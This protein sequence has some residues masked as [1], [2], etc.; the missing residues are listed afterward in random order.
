M[1]TLTT[2][3]RPLPGWHLLALA[4]AGLLLV[5]FCPGRAAAE[6]KPSSDVLVPYF[7]VDLDAPMLGLTTLFAVVNDDDK[8][9]STVVRVHSN[10]GIPIL[11][12]PMSI[13]PDEVRSFNLRDWVVYGRLPDRQLTP[14]EIAHVQAA[15]S[16]KPSPK[17]GLY[18]GS[19]T[20]PGLAVGYVVIRTTGPDRPD[21]LWGDYYMIDAQR[22]YFGAE[23]LVNIDP[24]VEDPPTCLRHGVRFLNGGNL[25]HGTQLLFWTE[26]EWPP[27]PAPKPIA[28]WTVDTNLCVYDEPGHH[29]ED[30]EMDILPVQVVKVDEL[31]LQPRFGWLDITTGERSF[32][33]EHLHTMQAPSA[34]LH[35]YCLPE[36]TGP[37][38]AA[39]DIQKYINGADA[40]F[41]PGPSIPVGSNLSWEFRVRNVGDLPLTDVVVSDGGVTVTCP[42]TELAPNESMTC[43][44]GG[45][46]KACQQQ[47][48][49]KVDALASDGTPVTDDDPA[50][51][52][53]QPHASLGLEKQVNGEDADG[54]DTDEGPWPH[55]PVGQ[56]IAWTFVVTNTGDVEL[57][58]VGVVDDQLPTVSCPKQVL[59]PG[60][61]MTCTASSPA[62][63]GTHRNVA[64]A[65]GTPPCGD[66]VTQ[67]DPANYVGWVPAPAIDLEKLVNGQDAD[68]PPGP[69]LELGAPVTWTF[70]VT[71][72]GDVPLSNVV[73]M[74]GQAAVSCPKTAL[75]TGESMT[76]TAQG[77]AQA[78]QQT[79]VASVT[80]QGDSTTVTD[81]DPA[82]YYGQFQASVSLEKRVNGEDADTEPGPELRTGT[83]ASWTYIAANTG[84]VRLT[85]VAVA[86]D[87]GVTVTCPK[88]VLEPGES[89]TCTGSA[90]VVKGQYRNVG[91]VTGKP[92]CGETV[93]ASDPANYIGRAPSI[94][95]EKLTNGEDADTP[96]GPQVEVGSTVLW[97]YVVTNT[98]DTVLT[99]IRVTD[100]RGVTVT[101]PK[102]E[103]QPAESMTCTASSMAVAGQY[104]NVGTAI[105]T[106]TVGP[107]VTATDPSHYFGY[108]SMIAIEKR[109]NGVDADTPPGPEILVGNPVTWKYWVT[110]TGDVPLTAVTVT[111]SDGVAVTCPQTT[112]AVSESMTC[113][114]SGTAVAGQHSNIGTATGNPPS[115]PSVSADDP[116]YYKGVTPGI[117]LEKLINGQDADSPPGPSIPVGSSLTWTYI[118]TNTG[119]VSLSGVGVTDSAGFTIVC[120]KTTLAPGES[121]TCTYGCA[122]GAV[123]C[124]PPEG[125]TALPGQQHNL[126]TATGT[127][128]D[129]T[130]VSDQD[131]AYY[132]GTQVADEG[133]TPGYWKN[134]TGSW[135]P[136]GYTTGQDVDTVFASVNTYYPTLGNASLWQALYFDGGS[137]NQ[138]A[139]EILL[140]A[141]VAALL[142]ASHPGVS[143]PRTEA[144]VIAD[145]N[146]ALLQSR[147]TML[148]LAAQLD[149]DNN[150]GCPLN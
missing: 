50:F 86:D 18:Y 91:T 49:G 134:H 57:T 42:Q 15:L 68:L 46:A 79:N 139:A 121:M 45:I 137:G 97:T 114:A 7:E 28:P 40:D 62:Q 52:F 4:L 11:T 125:C 5:L 38:G 26:R 115:G 22:S 101:C 131:H 78:C 132:F 102:T 36:E 94:S 130:P 27:S 39:I 73:V 31:D 69:T 55:I 30:H 118:V 6:I 21:V 150:L 100:D 93:T 25:T 34:T 32:I 16:G 148:A 88:T 105:G 113:S 135:P 123:K 81:T 44:L 14:A 19:E 59:Q 48:L 110:N 128:D 37:A 1:R 71:N 63:A 144:G 67:T 119:E 122:P 61:S 24:Q 126:G 104:A 58:D 136:T 47:N 74:D 2:G 33:T 51:Y 138:G 54:P 98:G 35:A 149:A 75:A 99:D 108:R 140:R 64:T 80:A 95:L 147:D 129:G 76:C 146:A 145:V 41:A 13:K 106:P 3:T 60:E 117:D 120:P 109:V 142:N 56:M 9:V 53:G 70:V 90:A 89:M 141:A 84:N 112:L 85:E 77:T 82:S 66:D 65:K 127:P 12:I 116:A 8:P 72:I 111:D 133:C 143:Y 23:T 103:L 10:W 107:D 124:V 92:P 43:T 83:T 29:V 96:P 20:D 87:R 17:D